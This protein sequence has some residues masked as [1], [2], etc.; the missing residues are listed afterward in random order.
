MCDK[1]SENTQKIEDYFLNAKALRIIR[2]FLEC[3]SVKNNLG[4]KCRSL[5]R[6]A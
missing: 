5:K 2:L 6:N 1:E 3:K 4:I